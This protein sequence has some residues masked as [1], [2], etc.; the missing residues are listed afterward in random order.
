MKDKYIATLVGCAIGDTIGMPVE[1]WKRERI[2]KYLGR[3][4]EPIEPFVIKD[5]QGKIVKKDEFGKLRY[6]K[7][8]KKGSYTDDTILTI[9]IAESIADLGYL[10]LEDICQRQLKA[11]K[12][13]PTGGFGGST[14]M[15]FN[16]LEKGISPLESGVKPGLGNGPAMKMS[17]IGLYMDAKDYEKGLEFAGLIARATHLDKRAIASGIVQAHA[18]YTLLQNPSKREFLDSIIEVCIKQEE[19]LDKDATLYEKGNLQSRLKWIKDNAEAECELAYNHLKTTS[20]AFESPPFTLFMFQKY[21]DN[22]IEGLLETVNY[23]GDCDTT[24]AIY[25]ALCGAK[26]GLIFPKDWVE[27]I[28]DKKKIQDIAEKIWRLG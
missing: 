23:G 18:I 5:G 4:T 25:G 20:L 13:R 10:N 11:Y 8:M 21:W 27:V 6:W 17:P 19:P 12:D 2:K 22:P 16:N 24:G 14:K 3:I 7:N 26:N 15:A 9:A 28:E 1:G